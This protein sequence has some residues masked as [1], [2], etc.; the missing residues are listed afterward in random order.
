[1]WNTN[2]FHVYIWVPSLRYLISC[3]CKY[4]KLQK[5]EIWSTSGTKHFRKEVVSCNYWVKLVTEEFLCGHLYFLMTIEHRY[6]G[7]YFLFRNGC[8]EVMALFSEA[9]SQWGHKALT[10]TEWAASSV[11]DPLCL[12]TTVYTAS[13]LSAEHRRQWNE[14]G[15]GS[16]APRDLT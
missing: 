16:H 4:F 13:C 9:Q 8:S 2:E 10:A 15:T 5:Y 12:S 7:G 1:M 3:I 14:P 6:L 11:S